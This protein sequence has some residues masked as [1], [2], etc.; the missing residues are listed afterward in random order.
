MR[1]TGPSGQRPPSLPL[2][3]PLLRA[4][5]RA[6]ITVAARP[7][8]PFGR[9]RGLCRSATAVKRANGQRIGT[10]PYGFNLA[11]DGT[12]LIPNEP[13]RA[14]IRDIRT[15]RSHG[16]TLG[17]IAQALTER[18][19]PTKTGKSPHWTH[20]AVARILNRMA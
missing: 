13:E 2:G 17:K 7:I 5:K 12:T 3:Y 14:V 20:Q 16:M 15:M 6:S 19:I 18:G 9:T 1:G 10:I 4:Q 8:P 11:D